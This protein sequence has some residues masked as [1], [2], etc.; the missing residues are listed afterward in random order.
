M[1]EWNPSVFIVILVCVVPVSQGYIKKGKNGNR[2]QS[3]DYQGIGIASPF[4][5]H[6]PLFHS[7]A[8]LLSH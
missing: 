7:L 6:S 3:V 8:S 5:V 1:A 4:V 2:E